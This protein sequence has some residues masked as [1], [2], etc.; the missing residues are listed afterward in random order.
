MTV[1]IGSRELSRILKQAGI[2]MSVDSSA[3][4]GRTFAFPDGPTRT[5]TVWMGGPT[6]QRFVAEVGSRL[7]ALHETWLLVP[8]FDQPAGLGFGDTGK[9]QV[10]VRFDADD[11]PALATY[12]STYRFPQAFYSDLWIFPADGGIAVLWSHHAQSDGIDVELQST[13]ETGSLLVALNEL[14]V[15]LQL[16]SRLERPL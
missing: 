13:A 8:R 5:V 7:L 1:A 3:G 9:K 10:A 2:R 15:Q 11:R 4:A 16:F 14:G 6:S 12:L